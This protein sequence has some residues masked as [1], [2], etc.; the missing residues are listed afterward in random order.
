MAA[1]ST[2]YE[3]PGR[4]ERIHRT[5]NEAPGRH[6][7]GRKKPFGQ[8]GRHQGGKKE[9]IEQPA[10]HQ[11]GTREAGKNHHQGGTRETRRTGL[12]IKS[13]FWKRFM[14]SSHYASIA[15]PPSIARPTLGSRHSVG[16]SRQNDSPQTDDAAPAES[17]RRFIDVVR[18]S[19]SPSREE[20]MLSVES[21]RRENVRP[22]QPSLRGCC[23]HTM[24]Q[25]GRPIATQVDE[26][27]DRSQPAD[28][29][30]SGGKAKEQSRAMPKVDRP[31]RARAK[32]RTQTETQDLALAQW[33]QHSIAPNAELA[34]LFVCYLWM[35]WSGFSNSAMKP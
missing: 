9:S 34:Q 28:R 10:R 29:R 31:A 17:G 30:H 32:A 7:E 1:R 3:A 21:V 13:R 8:L 11:S 12:P 16:L 35:I 23:L 24:I 2:A 27:H 26:I 19:L 33:T 20:R 6:Q 4:K 14:R 5:A 22:T 15:D 25:G 18:A